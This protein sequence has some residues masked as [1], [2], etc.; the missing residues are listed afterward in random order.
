MNR[1]TLRNLALIAAGL[2]TAAT[3]TFADSR[4]DSSQDRHDRNREKVIAALQPV[5]AATGWGRVKV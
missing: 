1:Q 5:G 3:V 4:G 2:M